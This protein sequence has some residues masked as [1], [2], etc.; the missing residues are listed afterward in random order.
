M[1]VATLVTAGELDAGRRNPQQFGQQTDDSRI[2][3]AV[4]RGR[5][6][7]HAQAAVAYADDLVAACAWQRPDSQVQIVTLPF[8]TALAAGIQI[9]RGRSSVLTMISITCK[10]M[11]AKIGD[12][13]RPPSD[14]IVRLNGRNTGSAI[15]ATK[16]VASL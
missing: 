16:I 8:K 2:G 4:G 12:M 1:L 3:L 5:G 9:G 15:M 11:I 7:A 14:G 6:D 10:R 13:S